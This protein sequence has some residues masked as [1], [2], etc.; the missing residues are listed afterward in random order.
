M[1]QPADLWRW[2]ITEN[3]KIATMRDDLAH[4]SDCIPWFVKKLQA[5]P[6]VGFP[7]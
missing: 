6:L 5:A 2:Y 1:Q 3:L 4:L 7:H